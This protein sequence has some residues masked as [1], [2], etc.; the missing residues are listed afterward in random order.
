MPM[1]YIMP[2]PPIVAPMDMMDRRALEEGITQLQVI[3]EERLGPKEEIQLG[4]VR[5]QELMNERVRLRE[6]STMA[7]AKVK[8]LE[9]GI[10][11]DFLDKQIVV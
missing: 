4:K 10:K 9:E 8:K 1:E 5:L 6:K 11:K 3:E 7:E 2:S